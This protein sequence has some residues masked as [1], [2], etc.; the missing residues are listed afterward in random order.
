MNRKELDAF[1]AHYELP[2]GSV[3]AA[4]ELAGA[5]PS[6]ADLAA[7]AVRLL[8]LAGVLSLAAGLVFFIAANWEALAVRG[9]FVLVEVVLVL[10]VVGALW[11]PPPVALGRYALLLAFIATGALLALF[12][13][14]Y[15]TGAD[16]YELFLTWTLLGVLFALAGQWSVTWAAWVLVLNMALSLYFSWQPQSGWLWF[17]LRA[18]G[19]QGSALLLVPMIV[20]VVLWLASGRLQNG[21]WAALAPAWLGRFALAWAFAYG[22][23]AGIFAIVGSDPDFTN[24]SSDAFTLLVLLGLLAAIAVFAARRRR[25][26]FP[27]ALI[28]GCLIVLTTTALGQFLDFDEIGVFFLLSLWLIVSSTVGGRLLMGVVRA[29]RAAAD[30][31]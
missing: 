14:T 20:N 1:V 24:N 19:S 26:V 6:R 12:G 23:W 2:H 11:K 28:T 29:W 9:R 27:L 7:F 3:E 8:K 31:R 13:Q 25:D 18:L 4:L 10:C 5:R 15:Q 21:R 22:T 16:V 17:L 30:E